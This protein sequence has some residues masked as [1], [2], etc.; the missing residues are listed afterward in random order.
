MPA[1]GIGQPNITPPSPFPLTFNI[2]E[3]TAT[4]PGLPPT[5]I[6]AAG[7]NATL[8]TTLEINGTALLT[9][10]L[11]AAINGAG[12]SIFHH[13][14]NLETGAMSTIAGGTLAP[15]AF[16]AAPGTTVT[17]TSPPFTL[18]IPAGFDA[19]TYRVLTHVHTGGLI[20]GAVTAFHDALVLMV[21]PPP[22]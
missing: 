6:F 1:P 16:G 22:G 18:A 20:A 10:I 7:V 17:V 2:S 11:A 3:V 21:V 15:A 5:T 4:A 14:E 12:L 8:S 9:P 19:G 13:L